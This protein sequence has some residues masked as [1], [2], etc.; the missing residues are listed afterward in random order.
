MEDILEKDQTEN[1]EVVDTAQYV[2]FTIDEETYGVDV[3]KVEGIIGMTQITHVPHSLSF[4][5]GVIN[6]RGSVVPVVDMRIKF[7]MDTKEYDQFTVILIVVVKGRQIGMIV[8]TVSDVMA[9]PVEKIQETPHFSTKIETDYIKGIGNIDDQLV[10]VLDV[11]MIL[12]QDELDTLQ[13]EE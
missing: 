5:K 3:L 13:A 9:I 10:I 8:D 2:T 11:D 6:L 7:N 12:S 4:M 1:N